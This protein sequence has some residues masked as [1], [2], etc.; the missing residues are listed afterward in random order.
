[1]LGRLLARVLVASGQRA[2]RGGRIAA[3][4][5]R[6]RAAARLAPRKAAPRLNLG[7]ALELLGD[8]E[9][10]LRAYEAALA[11]EPGNPFAHFNL[12]RLHHARNEHDAAERA[13]RGALEGKPDFAEAHI[14]L[15]NV[16][17]ARGDA[18]AA[19]RSLER[20]LALEPRHA[21]AWYN[22]AGMQWRLERHDAAED[23]LRRTLEIEPRFVPAYHLLSTLLRGS[24]RLNE[25]AQVLAAAR[26][27]APGRFDLESMELLTLTLSDGLSAQELFARQ[28]AFGERL[29]AALAP[30][31]APYVQSAD[32]ERRLRVGYVSCDFNR[33][34][35]AWFALPLLERHDRA[36]F[37]SICY[38]TATRPADEVTAQVR[39]A[40]DEWRDVAALDDAALA[41]L[42]RRDAIDI[43]VDLTGHAG[44]MRLG[45]FALQPAPV[46]ASWVGYLGSTG[47]TRIRYRLTDARADPPGA[48]DRLHTE[49]LVRLPHS[50]WCYRPV[51]GE[52][53][54]AGPPC[55]RNGYVTFGSFNH[56]PKLS[57]AARRCWAEILK[58]MPD[59]RLLLVGVP[60][61]RAQA[62]LLRDFAGHGV[63]PSQLTLRP[64]LPFGEYLRQLDAVDLALDSMPY[65]GG[66]TTFDALWMGVPVLA[67]S[68]ERSVE[69]SA[70]SILGALGLEDWVAGSAVDY[71][72]RALAH[73]ADG[74]RLAQLRSTLRE[75]LRASALM[76]EAGFARDMEGAYRALW[77][78]WCDGRLA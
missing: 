36:R 64:R 31:A 15:G 69:R 41:D 17:E 27:L 76:D 24:A 70:A 2:E 20:A 9:G 14:A 72:R 54:A 52:P 44:V 37:E 57:D 6:Y 38:S 45:V 58:R 11:A 51:H 46:Q 25:A 60:E 40:A 34:P 77:R 18:P 5:G 49:T 22:Y 32:P 7:A 75:R 29:E 66:T 39:A 63:D 68:G 8:A 10:A 26:R 55:A 61:G 28:R 42:I 16:L 23:A 65:G 30:P 21:G 12:G 4:C 56:A 35:V 59:A 48:A 62:G 53:H 47:L 19:A 78:A 13:L 43:L 1:V 50:L 33:H 74:A 73:A 3:A 71:V 67:R